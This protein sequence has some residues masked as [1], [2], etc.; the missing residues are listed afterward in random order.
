MLSSHACY[1]VGRLQ[2]LHQEA[3]QPRRGVLTQLPF[4]KI[5]SRRIHS[6]SRTRARAPHPGQLVARIETQLRLR[7]GWMAEIEAVRSNELLD[8]AAARPIPVE[9]VNVQNPGSP[10]R[11]ARPTRSDRLD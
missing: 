1:R 8:Q 4:A 2:R 5:L 7:D 6:K 11:R 9:T 10:S 3:F